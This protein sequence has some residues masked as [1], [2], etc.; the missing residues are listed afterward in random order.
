M[1]AI[2]DVIDKLALIHIEDRRLLMAKSK[3]K[4]TLYLPGGK[5]DSGE[6]DLQALSREVKEELEVTIDESRAEQFGR[7]VAQADGK[8]IGIQVQ[9]TCFRAPFSGVPRASTEIDKLVWVT[10]ND[11]KCCSAAA[12]IVINDLVSRGI[13]D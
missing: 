11:Q 5:R 4:D 10:S 9:L 12:K 7:Y 8:P 13:I 3:G 1:S 2:V 6:T